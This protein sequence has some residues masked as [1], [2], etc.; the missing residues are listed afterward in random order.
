MRKSKT[1]LVAIALA[2]TL[3]GSMGG[4]SVGKSTNKAS[5]PEGKVLNIWCWND[6][7]Q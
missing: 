3:L 2:A 1:A 7:F 5:G 4:C 6:E